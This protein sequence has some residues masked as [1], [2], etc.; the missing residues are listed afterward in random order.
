MFSYARSNLN[1]VK[2]NVNSIPR[3]AYAYLCEIPLLLAEATLDAL[4]KGKPKLTRKQVEQIVNQ[5]AS[6]KTDGRYD[7]EATGH[8]TINPSICTAER[9]DESS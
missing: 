6:L 9:R 8:T 5:V 7:T 2:Q 3:D 1:H 4:E